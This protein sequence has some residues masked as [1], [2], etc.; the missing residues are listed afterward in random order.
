MLLGMGGLVGDVITVAGGVALGRT[1][2]GCGVA[3][4]T[5]GVKVRVGETVGTVV[6]VGVAVSGVPLGAGELVTVGDVATAFES[7]KTSSR[8][9][10]QLL[11]TAGC[12]VSA[13]TL[14]NL[15]PLGTSKASAGLP[16]KAAFMKAFQIGT[17][18]NKLVAPFIGVLLALPTQIPV[19][20]CGV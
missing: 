17:A 3:V 6:R 5:T 8:V 12:P 4:G 16:P 19:T 1:M 18:V 9:L 13:H 7:R 2:I 15:T 10:L 20:N 11:F 14:T